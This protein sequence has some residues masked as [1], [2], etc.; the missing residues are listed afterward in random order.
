M[1]K[2]REINS[3]YFSNYTD[4]FLSADVITFNFTCSRNR[5]LRVHDPW[6]G[7]EE[8]VDTSGRGLGKGAGPGHGVRYDVNILYHYP[9][10]IP[11]AAKSI[12][13]L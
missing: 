11:F 8:F 7:R 2:Y 6:Y 5:F 10:G 13:K 4:N 3:C 12:K 9:N 1:H